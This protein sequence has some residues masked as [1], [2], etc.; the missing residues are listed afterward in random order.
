MG[1]V[2][3][4]D[5]QISNI[6][7]SSSQT[8]A[9]KPKTSD[10]TDTVVK[11][12]TVNTSESPA[13]GEPQPWTMTNGNIAA[14]GVANTVNS[15]IN[16][17]K[18]PMTV[19]LVKSGIITAA[20][21]S[22]PVVKIGTTASTTLQD[23]TTKTR[24]VT[25]T[26]NK[27]GIL[28]AAPF[29]NKATAGVTTHQVST[30]NTHP[31]TLTS[32]RTIAAAPVFN[33]G[34]GG[35]TIRQTSNNDSLFVLIKPQ[36]KNIS[37]HGFP[38]VAIS[39]I[40][41]STK[42]K[43]SNLSL[44]NVA[45]FTKSVVH[46]QK[47]L[48]N[49]HVT[50]NKE[51][52]KYTLPCAGQQRISSI[53]FNKVIERHLS[54]HKNPIS[55]TNTPIF[56]QS[57]TAKI[58]QQQQNKA[59]LRSSHMK[60]KVSPL[61]CNSLLP[62]DS[63]TSNVPQVNSKGALANPADTLCFQLNQ[64]ICNEQQQ[65]LQLILPKPTTRVQS[66]ASRTSYKANRV[67]KALPKAIAN[68]ELKPNRKH[69]NFIPHQDYIKLVGLD[70]C[71]D[72]LESDYFHYSRSTPGKCDQGIALSTMPKSGKTAIPVENND[73]TD[74]CSEHENAIIVDS[75]RSST[76]T[77]EQ[78]SVM[79]NDLSVLSEQKSEAVVKRSLVNRENKVKERKSLTTVDEDSTKTLA[80]SS[81]SKLTTGVWM[82]REDLK[83]VDLKP[84][85]VVEKLDL[86]KFQGFHIYPF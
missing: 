7:F 52:Q 45:P 78:H 21:A 39:N 62:G 85:V 80:E 63:S 69:L 14:I 73:S 77:T 24:S 44:E 26:I 15:D 30:T 84:K 68:A 55:Q 66:V 53:K 9:S 67:N 58:P 57:A 38:P 17:N 8:I 59:Y 86:T 75:T 79:S 19:T 29:V 10:K 36:I 48:T 37:S 46:D 16:I 25:L 12:F 42:L 61:N 3:L 11:C 83:R 28:T 27:N 65:R 64:P 51:Q 32:N 72:Y 2:A 13:A 54:L 47:P 6:D 33:R 5:V 49:L 23:S 1:E 22:A 41:T 82:T 20:A 43:I 76:T 40:H 70:L 74:T 71:L 31:V 18:S 81:G 34:T 35:T 56:S 4:K 60:S 50:G